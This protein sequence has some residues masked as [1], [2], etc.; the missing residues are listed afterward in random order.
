MTSR[1]N[2]LLDCIKNRYG[3]ITNP[4]KIKIPSEIDISNI[5]L[6]GTFVNYPSL[7]EILIENNK[8]ESIEPNVFGFK[9]VPNLQILSLKNNQI[10]SLNG[11]VFNNL[12][13]LTELKLNGNRLKELAENTFD[14]LSSLT[15]G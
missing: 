7:V 4:E 14:G 15:Y 9:I 13:K 10:E 1:E 6:D 3:H 8:I 2:K 12:T 11:D 5:I